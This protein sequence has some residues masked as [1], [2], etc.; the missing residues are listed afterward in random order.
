MFVL[1]DPP[2]GI[3]AD[4]EQVDPGLVEALESAV[5]RKKWPITLYG[6]TGVG[7]TSAMACMYRSAPRTRSYFDE[8]SPQWLN[9]SLKFVRKVQE[10]RPSD[11][12]GESNLWRRVSGAPLI[13]LDDLGV[14]PPSESAYG[15]IYELIDTRQ[16]KP[17]IYTSNLGLDR[18]ATVLDAR[19]A[20]R[21]ARGTVIHVQG[22]DRRLADTEI[23]TVG[24][25]RRA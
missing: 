16:S 3:E 6:D 7:K 2:S 14:V 22:V 12:R 21:L 11:P 4:W 23:I 13:C 10:F 17:A 25:S 18:L 24:D 8:E 9:T 20:S 15:I 1:R 19:V 5:R